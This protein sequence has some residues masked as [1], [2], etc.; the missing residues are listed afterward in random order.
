[1]KK[2]SKTTSTSKTNNLS[3]S[4]RKITSR[5]KT[6]SLASVSKTKASTPASNV[7][8]RA[9][10][11]TSRSHRTST[12]TRVSK[13]TSPKP[14]SHLS[15]GPKNLNHKTFVA[16]TKRIDDLLCEQISARR[17]DI[18]AKD[19]YTKAGLTPPTFYLHY[20]NISDALLSQEKSLEDNFYSRIPSDAK[21]TVIYIILANFIAQNQVYFLATAKGGS[22]YLLSKMIT[23]Y[24]SNLV[25]TRL[26]DRGFELYRGSVISS[27]NYWILIDGI[28]PS[29]TKAYGH[30]LS[31]IRPVRFW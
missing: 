2:T 9:L 3:S 15:R 8:I 26:S 30:H 19:L 11:S 16:N 4:T 17:I 18:K 12:P 21:R 10:K 25:G 23:T 22:H 29:T 6:E 7:N 27:I 31:K 20:R 14:P 13:P 5:S 28:S 24:R 1:M